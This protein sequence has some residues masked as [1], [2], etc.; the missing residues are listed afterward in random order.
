LEGKG[1]GIL[2]NTGMYQVGK[3]VKHRG[4]PLKYIKNWLRFCLKYGNLDKKTFKIKHMKK[5]RESIIQ[6]K[7][8]ALLNTMVDIERSVHVNSDTKRAWNDKFENFMDVSTR[9]IDSFPLYMHNRNIEP[10]LIDVPKSIY[11]M[12]LE[13]QDDL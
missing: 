3:I 6:D 8:I 13:N 7:S 9:I 5:A 12:I 2:L 11:E 1:K 4:I 10:P